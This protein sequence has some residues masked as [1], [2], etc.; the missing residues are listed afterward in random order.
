MGGFR[1]FSN[2]DAMARMRK[3]RTFRG[4]AFND[5]ERMMGV[6]V[7]CWALSS[8]LREDARVLD[9]ARSTAMRGAPTGGERRDE[10]GKL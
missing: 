4:L 7:V 6:E 2:R 10:S 5:R 9:A 3:N 8:I 1:T